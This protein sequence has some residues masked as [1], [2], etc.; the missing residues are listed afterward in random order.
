MR[1]KLST[2]D[3]VALAALA[4]YGA[5]VLA[6]VPREISNV[7]G[8]VLC[9]VLTGVASAIA[10]LPQRASTLAWFTAVVACALGTG[11]VGGLLLNLVP[12]GLVRVNWQTYALATTLIA[13]AV[14]RARGAGSEVRWRRGGFAK[15]TWASGAKVLAS[16]LLIG[17]AIFVSATSTDAKDRNFTELWLVPDSP[18]QAPFRATRAVVGIRS[19]ES[20]T[21]DFTIVVDTGAETMTSR[22]TLAPDQ[23]WTQNVA[24]DGAKASASVYRGGITAQPYRRVWI[25]VE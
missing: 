8:T 19:H 25:V 18:A 24:V 14:A 9:F 13:Y 20:S 4:C 10:I 22:V 21:E 15:P 7:T 6:F 3:L 16:T 5:S 23:I 11:I 12:S 2:L 17:T 1:T